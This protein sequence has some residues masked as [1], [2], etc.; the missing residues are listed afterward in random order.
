MIDVDVARSRP[1]YAIEVLMGGYMDRAGHACHPR[2]P[3]RARPA[4]K[5][6]LSQREITRH[7][8]STF[9]EESS[10]FKD[11]IGIGGGPDLMSY[12][13]ASPDLK[14]GSQHRR[15]A[16]STEH[17]KFLDNLR[18]SFTCRNCL[19]VHAG[20]R[21]GVPLEEQ[22]EHDLLWIRDELLRSEQRFGR[23]MVLGRTPVR[24]AEFLANRVNIDTG[25]YA[26]GNLTLMSIRG[27]RMLR[28]VSDSERIRLIAYFRPQDRGR[29][30]RR[31][32]EGMPS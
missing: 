25:A 31:K 10:L 19:F 8:W 14:R 28:S 17:L 3:D 7:F 20:F 1:R 5:C 27:S 9:F 4:R 13:L 22:T 11:W 12:G 32:T 15:C 26:T 2:H 30:R 18:L 23:N 21:A 24:S 29:L 6:D 16:I